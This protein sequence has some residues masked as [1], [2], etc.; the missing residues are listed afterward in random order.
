VNKGKKRRA[1]VSLDDQGEA[2]ALAVAI[3]VDVLDLRIFRGRSS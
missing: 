2:V 3:V 1:E